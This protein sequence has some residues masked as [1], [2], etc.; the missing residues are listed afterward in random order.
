MDDRLTAPL[1]PT[2]EYI[3]CDWQA[4]ATTKNTRW[5]AWDHKEHGPGNMSDCD[6]FLCVPGCNNNTRGEGFEPCTPDGIRCAPE[7]GWV[8]H[9]LCLRC[10]RVIEQT[11][12][13]V[14]GMRSLTADDSTFTPAPLSH[15][16][17][18]VMFNVAYAETDEATLEAVRN[19]PTLTN[20]QAKAIRLTAHSE[21]VTLFEENGLIPRDLEADT[22][23]NTDRLNA[24][25][26]SAAGGNF[27]SYTNGWA[28][29]AVFEA[30][31]RMT[32]AENRD[33]LR[34]RVLAIMNEFRQA[35]NARA[36][37]D[38]PFE[39]G[40][41]EGYMRMRHALMGAILNTGG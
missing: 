9:Y 25:Y 38:K 28:E 34:K 37:S 39:R 40:I 11:T 14:I 22:Q 17:T 19:A 15:T 3:R 6:A 2:S 21:L 41:A 1:D 24:A 12:G 27:S 7:K 35:E 4:S 5:A 36:A 31:Q 29:R 32:M 16:S 8:G 20:D 26:N 10:G 13:R 30:A 23:E 33:E 18:V